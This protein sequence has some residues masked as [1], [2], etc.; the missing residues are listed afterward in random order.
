M[1]LAKFGINLLISFF[2]I[3][4][5]IILKMS[6]K[7]PKEYVVVIQDFLLA[8]QS[9]DH[10]NTRIK[11]KQVEYILFLTLNET[12]NGLVFILTDGFSVYWVKQFEYRDFEQIR[13]KLGME[14]NY[15]GY[16]EILRESILNKSNL[17]MEIKTN[18]K[19]CEEAFLSLKYQITKGVTLNGQFELG[20]SI[21]SDKD[22]KT[23]LKINKNFI[24]D[25][26]Y[27]MENNNKRNNVLFKDYEDRVN[28]LQT[29]VCGKKPDS[30]GPT[31]IGTGNNY[32]K[33]ESLKQK[34]KTDLINPNRKKIVS[35]GAKFDAQPINLNAAIKETLEEGL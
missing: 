30:L 6:Q 20:E 10:L 13:N 8:L 7:N 4:K 2:F 28:R 35:R 11:H 33:K 9:I 21:R 1:I 5:N 3:I 27:Y 34:A 22:L 16:F 19:N 14:G 23:F 12:H 31:I 18:N 32:P 24:F 15:E 25:L 17:A 26:Q 29:E